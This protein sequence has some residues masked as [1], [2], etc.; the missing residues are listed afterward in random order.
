MWPPTR[1]S[2]VWLCL[3]RYVRG[4]WDTGVCEGWRDGRLEGGRDWKEEMGLEVEEAGVGR[5]TREFM[6]KML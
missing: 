6:E 2:S 3:T 1:F 5:E 4:G